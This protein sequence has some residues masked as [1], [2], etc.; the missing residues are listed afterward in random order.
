[1]D[2]ISGLSY[3][4]FGLIPLSLPE[5]P[6]APSRPEEPEYKKP[7]LFN[8]KKVLAENAALE[9]K[10]NEEIKNMMRIMKNIKLV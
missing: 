6:I 3:S 9:Q 8:K 7:G 2:E 1:M 4:T 5:K 10:Y